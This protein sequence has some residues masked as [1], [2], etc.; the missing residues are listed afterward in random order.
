MKKYLLLFFLFVMFIPFMVNAETC[1]NDKITISSITVDNKSDN[2][3]ELSEATSSNK[4][5]NLNLSMYEVGDYIE[6]KFVVKNDSKE[7]YELDK[8][9]LNINS[10]YISYSF[11]T[12][13]NSSIV[14]ANSSKNVTLR[15]EYKTKVQEDKFE[16]GYYNDNKAMKIQLSNKKNINVSDVLNNPNTGVKTYM[17]IIMFLLLISGSL[18]IVLKEKDPSKL[19]L[20]IIGTIVIVPISV[21][22]LCKCEINITSNITI[23]NKYTGTI[24]RFSTKEAYDGDNIEDWI[25]I[26]EDEI[27]DLTD[28]Y[29][30]VKDVNLINIEGIHNSFYIKHKVVNDIITN[31]YVCHLAD[32]E[33]CFNGNYEEDLSKLHE[34]G[35][36]ATDNNGVCKFENNG[37]PYCYHGIGE[38]I[39]HMNLNHYGYTTAEY[40]ALIFCEVASTS[41]TKCYHD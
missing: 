3:E 17:L 24:Y 12:D 8:N 21:N 31:S 26:T 33:Y 2:V 1:E 28:N 38:E 11:E 41:R 37:Y 5:I 39:I 16:N 19:M 6:Y 40:R 27:N 13:D 29:E 7:D 35:E 14:K 23:T 22:A 30:Y 9:N 4:N 15:I 36:Y 32:K 18:Y 10:D 34:L 20:L 25:A